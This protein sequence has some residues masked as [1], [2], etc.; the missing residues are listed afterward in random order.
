[1]GL[2]TK[3]EFELQQG[4]PQPQPQP[5]QRPGFLQSLLTELTRAPIGLAKEI[6]ASALALSGL[7]ASLLGKQEKSERAQE[8]L[9]TMFPETA[10][11]K[12]ERGQLKEPLMQL[13][14]EAT[15]TGAYL[16]PFGKG[17]SLLSRAVI[18]GAEVGGLHEFS[19][20]GATPL[21]IAG[22]AVAGGVTAGALA[23][24]LPGLY[25]GAK[26][27]KQRAFQLLP[28][29]R[30]AGVTDALIN[31]A[32]QGGIR[33]LS[34]KESHILATGMKTQERIHELMGGFAPGGRLA[35]DTAE[36]ARREAARIGVAPTVVKPGVL[37]RTGSKLLASQYEVPRNLARTI[38]LNETV[39]KLAKYGI[40]NIDDIS[41]AAEQITGANGVIT[42]ATRA[43]VAGAKG[44]KTEGVLE[45]SRSL[46]ED[47]A[48]TTTAG[49]KFT[50]FI[51]KGII[52]MHGGPRGSLAV[53]ANPSNTFGFIQQLERQAAQLT[54][55]R[56]AI[57]ISSQDRALSNSFRL[58][59][60]ELKNRLFTQAGADKAIVSKGLL[61]GLSTELSKIS[62]KLGQEVL[63]A[64]S[65]ADLRRLALPF[66][67]GQIAAT[68]TE[69]GRQTA[70]Q[71]LGG[72]A[73]GL[74]RFGQSPFNILAAPLEALNAPIGGLLTRGGARLPSIPTIPGAGLVGGAAGAIPRG[75]VAQQVYGQLGARLPSLF[76][77]GAP[78][79]EAPLP[80]QLPEGEVTPQVLGQQVPGITGGPTQLGPQELPFE[81]NIPQQVNPYPL[82]NFIQD[83]QR[84]P[85]NAALYKY[86]YEQYQQQFAAQAP[87]QLT[88]EAAKTKGK[89]DTAELIANR[90]TE[91]LEGV[92]SLA[93]GKVASIAGGVTG[94][95]LAT[96]VAL[97]E[98][99]RQA[100][101]GPLARAISGEVGVLTDYDIKRAERML[102]KV[103]DSGRLRQ[104]KLQELRDEIA[105]RRLLLQTGP[106]GQQNPLSDYLNQGQATEIPGYDELFQMLGAQGIQ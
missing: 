104:Q 67:R 75:P 72:A 57:A 106:Q 40:T 14:Q 42:R 73:R 86:I 83:I 30:A 102:P 35:Q 1:M 19:R 93:A 26:A 55:G 32:R 60:D 28:E 10:V 8:V 37:E 66:V 51:R 56:P 77:A 31:K 88:G 50:E 44:V 11:A 90:A 3:R 46:A 21:S 58:V 53:G 48:I 39:N 4:Q 52:S 7:T 84:D 94:G 5:E 81:Q 68:E 43:A 62:P 47:P 79:E 22:G 100:W 45:L 95:A 18:P 27:I 9:R 29:E 2:L 105:G 80:G 70:T 20:P 98:S 38:K 89:I 54:R 41:P 49:N 23:K 103:S 24:L 33:T 92:P 64:N 17:A 61:S 85:K 6:P 16:I 69:L 99:F 12:A 71:T 65:V 101:L 25:G 36:F 96:D 59:A 15:G 34:Q 13:A 74:G 63:K 97:Y 87:Q 82:E 78:P 91:L 76:A